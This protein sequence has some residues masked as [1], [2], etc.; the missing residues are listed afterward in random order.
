MFK[1]GLGILL[2]D[3]LTVAPRVLH[4]LDLLDGLEL[5]E[6]DD[7]VDLVVVQ[8]LH[9]LQVDVQNAML[10]LGKRVTFLCKDGNL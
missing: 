6:Q 4:L 8:P 3:L 10:V 2:R 7:R 1:N 9:R 5:D